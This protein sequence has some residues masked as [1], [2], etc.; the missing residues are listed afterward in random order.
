M[1]SMDETLNRVKGILFGLAAGDKIGGPLRMA[2]QTAESLVQCNG[3]DVDNVAGRYLAWW[4][5]EGFD[6]GPTADKVFQRVSSGRSFDEAARQVHEEKKGYT[7]GCNPAHRAAPLAMCANLT[8][9][10]LANAATADS[11]LTHYHPLA[12]DVSAAVVSLCRALVCGREWSKALEMARQG[13]LPQT[14]AALTDSSESNLNTGGFAPDVLAAAVHFVGA[15]SQFSAALRGALNFA[16][17]ANYCPVLAG[18]IG[19]ARW[20]AS[21]VDDDL[22]SQNK[23][24]MLRVMES[25]EILAAGWEKVG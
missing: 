13:R 17:P 14:R 11:V 2:L 4:K 12:G 18:S 8:D 10:D 22:I 25:A 5:Q 1:P 7:A 15:N 19:G 6:T 21:S 9:D 24:L 3:F 20:G 23:G 16:G